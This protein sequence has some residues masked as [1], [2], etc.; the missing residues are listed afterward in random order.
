MAARVYIDGFNLHHGAIK[1]TAFKWLDLH[2]LA[3]ALPRGCNV[4]AAKYFTARV[5]DVTGHRRTLGLSVTGAHIGVSHG[6]VKVRRL[7]TSSGGEGWQ[8]AVP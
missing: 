4:V 7:G 6:H 3:C 2:A 1:G 8:D 5:E